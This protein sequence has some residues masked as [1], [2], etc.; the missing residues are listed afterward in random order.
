MQPRKLILAALVGG[1][2]IGVLLGLAADPDMVPAP[3][4]AWRKAQPDRIFTESQ[5]MV[6]AGPQDF[7]PWSIDRLPTWKRRA[8]E[9]QL[10]AYEPFPPIDEPVPAAEPIPEPAVVEQAPV[11]AAPAA[12]TQTNLAAEAASAAADA[13]PDSAIA[14]PA[15]EMPAGA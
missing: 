13:A 15:A 14:L 3:E 11:Q 6:D 8:M 7:S 12:E 9:R 2:V 5:S 10:A 4:P 1:P